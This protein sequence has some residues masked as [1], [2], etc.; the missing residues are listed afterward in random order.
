MREERG[1]DG[2]SGSVDHPVVVESPIVLDLSATDKDAF[3]ATQTVPIEGAPIPET[4]VPFRTR[5]LFDRS[6]ALEP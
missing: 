4:G 5:D 1:E 2:L 3:E 6:H